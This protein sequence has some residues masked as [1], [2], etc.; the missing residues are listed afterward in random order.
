M[1]LHA[2]WAKRQLA[3]EIRELL[4]IGFAC[5]VQTWDRSGTKKTNVAACKAKRAAARRLLRRAIK[6]IE[7]AT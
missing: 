2:R 4:L 1:S 7:T 3:A 5:N 6:A